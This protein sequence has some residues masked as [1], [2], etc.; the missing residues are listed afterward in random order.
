MLPSGEKAT[1]LTQ[2]V[3]PESVVEDPVAT[4]HSLTVLSPDPDATVPPSR[5]KATELTPSVCPESVVEDPVAT[6][7]SLMVPS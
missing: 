2:N 4:S 5:E 7:H 1:E 6:S 3:C